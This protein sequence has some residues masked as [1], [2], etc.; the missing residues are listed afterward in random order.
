MIKCGIIK[1]LF[2]QYI[3]GTASE[4]TRKII[5][6]HIQNCEECATALA[7][8]KEKMVAQLEKNNKESVNAIKQVGRKLSRKK[9]RIA[10]IASILTLVTVCSAAWLAFEHTFVISYNPNFFRVDESYHYCEIESRTTSILSLY[11]D[12]RYRRQPSSSRTLYID[13]IWVDVT[14]F[15]FRGTLVDMLRGGAY[16]REHPTMTTFARHNEVRHIRFF[17]TTERLNSSTWLEDE[18]FIRIMNS[19]TLIWSGTIGQQGETSND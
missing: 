13:G 4:D 19:S 17:Y 11:Y 14:L 18:E 9:M 7:K 6:E 5:D 2:V 8:T 15:Q 10:V 16:E 3:C 1:D 12:A